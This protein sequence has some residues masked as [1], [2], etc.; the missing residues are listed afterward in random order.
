[1]I[2]IVKNSQ[3]SEPVEKNTSSF[4]NAEI[5]QNVQDHLRGDNECGHIKHHEESK[6]LLYDIL[7]ASD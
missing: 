4:K 2:K 6:S 1:M 3:E 7:T 5:I